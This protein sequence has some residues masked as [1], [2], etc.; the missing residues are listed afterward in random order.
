M[1]VFQAGKRGRGAKAASRSGQAVVSPMGSKAKGPPARPTPPRRSFV[2][3][4]RMGL[5]LRGD[6][7]LVPAPPAAAVE[8]AAT[9]PGRKRALEEDSADVEEKGSGRRTAALS[10]KRLCFSGLSQKTAKAAEDLESQGPP[11]EVLVE[12][13]EEPLPAAPGSAAAEQEEAAVAA[14]AAAPTRCPA[15][16]EGPGGAP[17]DASAAA[18]AL[19]AL[20]QSFQ[21]K[22]GKETI[23]SEQPTAHENQLRAL[24]QQHLDIA[25]EAARQ[26]L[27]RRDAVVAVLQALRG[28]I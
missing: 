9:P 6:V 16:G 18:A 23:Q 7:E 11:T 24:V 15:A 20:L 27:E 19:Q 3:L 14:P 4:V 2:E 12:A 21:L 10:A 5:R 17:L 28:L 13:V 26:A 1:Q 22:A 25:Q 8:D